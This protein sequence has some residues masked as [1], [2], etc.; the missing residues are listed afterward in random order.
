MLNLLEL[1]I[2]SG[3]ISET[4]RR[5][6]GDNIET[7]GLD[8]TSSNNNNQYW[9]TNICEWDYKT[10]L[11]SWI[12][13][14]IWCSPPCTEFSLIKGIDPIRCPR[15]IEKGRKP[16]LKMLEILAWL[17]AE[18]SKRGLPDCIWFIENPVGLMQKQPEIIELEQRPDVRRL[19]TDQCMYGRPYRKRTY[20]WTNN[21][22]LDLLM[23]KGEGCGQKRDNKHIIGCCV[24]RSKEERA[25]LKAKGTKI[26]K[27]Y[28]SGRNK[29]IHTGQIPYPLCESILSQTIHT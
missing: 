10:A 27:T 8:I 6:G 3:S 2:G 16:M 25:R 22:T 12:P 20:I 28:I 14:V 15:D 13:D 7:R 17:E 9:T 19:T 5:L 1:F 23:C 4:A 24:P 11:S 29:S 18:R 21:P 26:E